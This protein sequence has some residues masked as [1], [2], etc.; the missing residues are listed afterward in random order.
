MTGSSLFIPQKGTAKGGQRQRTLSVDSNQTKELGP[1]SSFNNNITELQECRKLCNKLEK[2]NT[3]EDP[4]NTDFI[5]MANM[6]LNWG[7]NKTTP[8]NI[9]LFFGGLV[10][11]TS[12]EEVS[13][14]IHKVLAA[15]QDSKKYY[16]SWKDSE[17]KNSTLETEVENSQ[18]RVAEE[19]KIVKS[20]TTECQILRQD[21]E[22]KINTIKTLTNDVISLRK[23]LDDAHNNIQ[24]LSD[25]GPQEEKMDCGKEPIPGPGKR[26][27]TSDEDEEVE[28]KENTSVKRQRNKKENKSDKAQ[29]KTPE[30]PREEQ[31]PRINENTSVT[32]ANTE[33]NKEESQKHEFPANLI[34]YVNSRKNIKKFKDLNRWVIWGHDHLKNIQMVEETIEKK[35]KRVLCGHQESEKCDCNFGFLNLLPKSC[36]DSNGDELYYLIIE[37]EGGKQTQNCIDEAIVK[38]ADA[39]MVNTASQHWHSTITKGKKSKKTTNKFF[40]DSLPA[41]VAKQA[42]NNDYGLLEYIKASIPCASAATQIPGSQKVLIEVPNTEENNITMQR[43]SR[44]GCKLGSYVRR[45]VPEKKKPMQCQNC[46]AFDHKSGQCKNEVKCGKCSG[47][48]PTME[49]PEEIDI[50]CPNCGG[51]HSASRWSC[52]KVQEARRKE[53][54]AIQEKRAA[55][56]AQERQDK[57]KDSKRDTEGSGRTTPKTPNNENKQTETRKCLRC[58]KV[59]HIAAD[60]SIPDKRKCYNCQATGHIA[61]NCTIN[62]RKSGQNRRQNYSNYKSHNAPMNP[63]EALAQILNLTNNTMPMGTIR[64]NMRRTR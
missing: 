3:L 33:G 46:Q 39:N 45:I 47:A 13:G 54:A 38:A 37:F 11:C 7:L 48:H 58:D 40:L 12:D 9:K 53:V 10:K 4:V 51:A 21:I 44:D 8:S 18:K 26:K 22:D 55:K 35:M 31:Q 5:I 49:H 30:E 32:N 56:K 50:K 15:M 2:R 20:L 41:I 6:A 27:K 52:R 29:T 25:S 1:D 61:P 14:K 24:A 64:N 17:K 16:D 43:I 19:T 36:R 60:C 28:S 57:K 62:R 42:K 59:G 63:L 23:Q 34:K